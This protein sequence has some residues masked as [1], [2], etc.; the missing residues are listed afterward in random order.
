MRAHDHSSKR[1]W[2][3]NGQFMEQWQL[4]AKL[5]FDMLWRGAVPLSNVHVWKVERDNGSTVRNL[6]EAANL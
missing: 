6:W 5:P 1:Q 3:K 2:I 4:P